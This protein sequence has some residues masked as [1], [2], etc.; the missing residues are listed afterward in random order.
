VGDSDHVSI[1]WTDRTPVRSVEPGAPPLR[2][3]RWQ[4]WQA[5]FA[6]AYRAEIGAFL[7]AARGEEPV[8]ATVHDAV[9]AQRIAEAARESF[10]SGRRVAVAD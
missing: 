9:A 10:E 4:T 5:R 6:E 7:A 2:E 8:R 1:G 3:D